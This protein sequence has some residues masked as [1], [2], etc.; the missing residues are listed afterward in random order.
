MFTRS[1]DDSEEEDETAAL[2]AELAKIK[3]EKADE[4]A[5]LVCVLTPSVQPF[6]ISPLTLGGIGRRDVR[7]IGPGPRRGD[8]DG[9]SS[10]QPP[11]RARPVPLHPQHRRLDLRG[12]TTMGR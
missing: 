4:K 3:Q 2:M 9:Q 1:E 6:S 7:P 8:R 12:E 11:K 10:A 5:R